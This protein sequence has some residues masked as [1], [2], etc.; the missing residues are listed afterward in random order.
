MPEDAGHPGGHGA[1]VECQVN[2]LTGR[3]VQPHRGHERYEV[4]V[5]TRQGQLDSLTICG[6]CLK[7]LEHEGRR[8]TEAAKDGKTG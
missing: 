5:E 8:L 3:Q 4:K 7:R 2:M 6:W 1:G